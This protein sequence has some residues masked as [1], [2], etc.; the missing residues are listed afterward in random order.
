M[1]LVM[2]A[3]EDATPWPLMVPDGNTERLAAMLPGRENFSELGI[4]RRKP[5]MD[6]RSTFLEH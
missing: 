5:C 1:E 6:L 4:V 3:Q 2:N